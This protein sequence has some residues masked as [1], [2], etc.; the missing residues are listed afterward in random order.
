[1]QTAEYECGASNT[2]EIN[3]DG[4]RGY[5]AAQ[6]DIA[7]PQHTYFITDDEGTP[8]VAL[9]P[10]LA[11]THT[12]S[13]QMI[14]ENVCRVLVYSMSNAAFSGDTKFMTVGI[15][16]DD[17]ARGETIVRLE[18]IQLVTTDRQPVVVEFADCKLTEKDS[19]VEGVETGR[20]VRVVNRDGEIVVAGMSEGEEAYL[21]SAAGC[22]VGVWKAFDGECV[23]EVPGGIYILRAGTR[24]FKII[25]E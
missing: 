4:Q 23:F 25:A 18:N 11:S 3:L 10:E 14:G 13:A 20:D 22:L 21:Y 24:S 17:N 5:V 12:L 8:A 16:F 15:G 7:L 9:V 2:F 1:M 19:S 6:F